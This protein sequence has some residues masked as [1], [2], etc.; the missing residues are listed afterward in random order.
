MDSRL[1]VALHS[2]GAVRYGFDGWQDIRE[3]DTRPNSLGLHLV[4]IDT[5]RLRA[6]QQ[7]DLT[8][9]CGS[10]WVGRDFRVAVVS[11]DADG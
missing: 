3:D 9:R 8:Y 6:G 10:R 2:P 1:T 7:V 5:V 11:R 4:E